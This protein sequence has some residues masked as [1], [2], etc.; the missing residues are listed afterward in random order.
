MNKELQALKEIKRIYTWF[1]EFVYAE[2]IDEEDI[3]LFNIIEKGLKRKE[4]LEELKRSFDRQIEKK[5]K[6]IEI[7]KE[8]ILK[9]LKFDDKKQTLSFMFGYLIF[10][11]EIEDKTKY[12][13]LKEEL[14]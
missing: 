9:D 13:L 3:N 12:D 10:V 2:K 11:K 14:K 1:Q 7:I 8:L 6:A 4:E 5:L